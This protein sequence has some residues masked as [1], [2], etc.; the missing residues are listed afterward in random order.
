MSPNYDYVIVGSGIAGL[1]A[2]LLARQHGSVLVITKSSIDECNTRYAQGGI[3]AALGKDDSAALHAHDTVAAGA[4]LV[5]EAAAAILA[6][7]AA[8]RIDDLVRIGVP[9]DTIE[10]EVSL[11]REGAH[12]AARVLHAGGDFTGAHIELTLT[13]AVRRAGVEVREYCLATHIRVEDGAVIGVLTSDSA[14]GV[15]NE[16]S[17]GNLILASGGAGQMYQ[18]TTNP[19]VATGDG[20][21][22]A[23]H[24]GAEIADM[25]FFQFHPTALRLPGVRAFLIS[26]A[27]RGEGGVLLN[28][29]GKRFMPEYHPK[30]ELAPRDIVAR[31]IHSEMMAS[32]TDHVYLDVTHLPAQWLTAR[33]P[34]IYRFCQEHGLDI[35]SERIPVSPAAHYTTGGIRTNTWGETT[36]TGLYACGECASTGVHGA[37]RLASNSLLETVVFAK[38]VIE[39]SL[40]AN[41]RSTNMTA[42]ALA[43]SE[44][45]AGEAPVATRESLQEIMWRDVGIVRSAT[46]LSRAKALL[47]AWAATVG[48]P[49][50]TAS[51]ELANLL[52]CSRLTAEAALL[53]EESR[54]A[55]YRSDFPEPQDTWRRHIVFRR[56]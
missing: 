50:D 20:I 43:L 10:G 35:A 19:A 8:D 12:T 24:A 11:G 2:A 51:H 48:P 18:F 31:A 6:S 53:R 47:A 46:S 36:L 41:P 28:A 40:R 32:G 1:Y 25:E 37:N 14:P 38:R 34:Q 44:V 4:G 26:E 15:E 23:Y 16:I 7:G 22:L 54:G 42:G 49:H 9:F 45:E 55:H 29:A 56:S 5:D 13:E 21:A 33:F 39:Q 30:A 27:V 3:A 17:C 52:T